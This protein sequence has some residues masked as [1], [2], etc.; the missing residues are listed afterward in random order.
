MSPC[1]TNPAG[2]GPDSRETS[3]GVLKFTFP[4]GCSGVERGG[5]LGVGPRDSQI[6]TALAQSTCR[7]VLEEPCCLKA[8]FNAGRVGV[9]IEELEADG[10]RGIAPLGHCPS[11][12]IEE[13]E[14]VSGKTRP[15]K[16]GSLQICLPFFEQSLLSGPADSGLREVFAC[17]DDEPSEE[18]E[19]E[20]KI[21][22]PFRFSALFLDSTSLIASQCACQEF[23]Q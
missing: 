19:I 2:I 13:L 16:S 18:E 1:G 21:V 20:D 10:F 12:S 8:D 15:P 4:A 23:P 3:K 11:R 14:L 5:V 17:G 22:D 7:S 6:L 9:G